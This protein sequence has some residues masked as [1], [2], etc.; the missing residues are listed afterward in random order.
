MGRLVNKIIVHC[1]ASDVPEHDDIEVIRRWH[2]ARGWK[3]I[4]Y[5]HFIDKAGRIFR[6]RKCSEVGAHCKGENGNSIGI[7]L[8]GLHLFTGDQFES[9][10]YLI[11]RTCFIHEID[12]REVYE[13]G[14]FNPQKTCPNFDLRLV[15]PWAKV[16]GDGEGYK[17]T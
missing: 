5:H 15:W 10:E 3:D 6:G 2:L 11:N 7:C 8:S 4:G 9:L 14:Y 13:H 16:R 1:S 12:R 17:K